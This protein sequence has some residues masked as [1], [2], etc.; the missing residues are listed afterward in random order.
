MI[1]RK[2]LA[3][4]PDNMR[5]KPKDLK[6]L[7]RIGIAVKMMGIFQHHIGRDNAISHKELFRSVF[8]KTETESLA[9]EL[10]WEYA[11]RAMHML[12]QRTKCFVGSEF[13]RNAWCYFVVKDDVDA[14]CYI[15]NL[16]KSI[17]DEGN[18]EESH[19]GCGGEVV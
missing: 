7:T 8:G 9:D 10:R 4:L 5:I 3:R 18:A 17:S 19:Q 2:L 6:L 12:R 11:K 1:S 13:R 15:K 16:D 14:M